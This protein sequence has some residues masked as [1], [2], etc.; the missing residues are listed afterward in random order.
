MAESSISTGHENGIATIRLN[1]PDKLNAMT[2]TMIS[3]FVEALAKA[4]R[5][6]AVRVVVVTGS[7]RAFCA[8]T[9]ISAGFDLPTGGDPA[10]GKWVPP[11]VGGALT[12]KLYRMKKPVLAAVNGVA[13]GI[14]ATMLLAMDR[15]FV[16]EGARF[17]FPFARRGIMA[18]SVSSW[19]LPR[20]VGLPN[21]LDWMLTGRMI[22]ADE[23]L[24]CGLADEV[25]PA[26]DLV[27]RVHAYART[28][29]DNT[30]AASVAVNRQL[31]WRMASG[32]A[33]EEAHELE[34]RALAALLAHADSKEGVSSFMEKR[35]PR[36]TST[37]ADAD[38]MDGWWE[39]TDR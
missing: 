32:R 29:I 3:D 6:D 16:A 22:E 37:A 36:F 7:G 21:A 14:G 25:L 9:D 33:P 19:F 4:E 24:R 10:T 27:A 23:A 17:T 31:L 28:I 20:V 26:D 39:A 15:R 35:P 18:E 12:L 1:R 2:T 13:A 8:G 11:D 30:S 5:D 38:F 34:S